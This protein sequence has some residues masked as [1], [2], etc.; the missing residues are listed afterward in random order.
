MMKPLEAFVN[1]RRVN[2]AH[3]NHLCLY[4]T[5]RFTG[6]GD[7]IRLVGLFHVGQQW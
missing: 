3:H 2:H 6:F 5:H 4:T 7:F 1:E